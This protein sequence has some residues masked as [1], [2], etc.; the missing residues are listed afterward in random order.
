MRKVFKKILCPINLRH[1]EHKQ[2]AYEEAVRMAHNH[3]AELI[4]AT[5]APEIER[6]LNIRDSRKFWGD[7]LEEFLK[8][9]PP[10]DIPFQQIVRIGSPHRQIVKLAD[11]ENVDLIVMEAANPKVSDYLLGTTSTHVVSHSRA[12]VYVVRV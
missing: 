1:A 8:N 5:V 11:E 7:K 3:G 2:R 10:G 4:V 6:N 12:S 9:N